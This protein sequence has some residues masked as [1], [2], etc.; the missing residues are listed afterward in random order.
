M[1]KL[2]PTDREA[3]ASG[4]H[5]KRYRDPVDLGVIE[6]GEEIAR[7]EPGRGEE[8]LQFAAREVV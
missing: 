5:G 6:V 3:A 8:L 1:I 7:R 2:R 4:T